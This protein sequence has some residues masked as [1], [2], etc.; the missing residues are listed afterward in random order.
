MILLKTKL[1]RRIASIALGGLVL[2]MVAGIGGFLWLRTSLPERSG[3]VAVGG[4]IQD[5][6]IIYDAHGVPHITA[7]SLGD[8]YRALGYTHAQDRL[9]QMDFMRRLGAGRLSEVVGRQTLRIDRTMR[10]LGLYRLAGKTVEAMPPEA[11]ALL[12][13]YAEGVNAY[14]SHRSGALPPEFLLLGYTPERWRPADSL[15]WGRLMALRLSGNWQTEA[16]RAGMATR[17]SASQIADLWPR[18]NAG[19][20]PTLAQGYDPAA[21][22]SLLAPLLDDLPD[23]LRQ[24]SASN[25]WV[26]GPQHSA[27]GAPLLANDP[28]LGFR[29]PGL[30]Y[31]ARLS[32]PGLDL[33]GATVPGVPFHILG[34]NNR[35]AWAFTT[36]D[37]DTQDLFIERL[38]DGQPGH[39]DTPA[40]PVRFDERTETIRIKGGETV[41][42][43][44]RATRHGPVVSDLNERFRGLLPNDHIVA[45]SA[46]ALSPDDLTPLALLNMNRA[47]SWAEFRDALRN[48]HSPQQNVTYADG[49]GNIGFMAPGRVPVRRNGDGSM[50]AQGWTGEQDW[51]GFIP[52]DELPGTYNPASGRIVN[53]N[54]RIVPETYRWHL[55]HDWAAPYRARRIFDLLDAAP[56]QNADSMGALQNDVV[57]GA[58]KALLPV[59]LSQ[60]ARN[61]SSGSRASTPATRRASQ[62]LGILRGWNGAMRRELSAPLIFTAW[63]GEVNRGL[64]ADELGPYFGGYFGLRPRVVLHLLENSRQWCD[65]VP[66]PGQESCVDVVSTAL[67]RALEDLEQRFGGS[68]D[69]WQWGKA[70]QAFF[71]HPVFGHVPVL[72]NL[73]DIRIESDG[74]A[75]TVNRAQNRISNRRAPFANVHGPGYRAIY[76]L[77][78]PANS[79]FAI[80][81]GQSGNPLSPQYADLLERWRDG[82][83]LGIARTRAAALQDALGRI[84][85]TAAP[86]GKTP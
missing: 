69:D 60:T 65:V 55:S 12:D 17:L 68:P 66:T 75:E 27:T 63:L 25:S 57:S 16:L 18:D 23:A 7:T 73:A 64:Y 46:T 42:L 31:L 28:H 53:A 22:A 51:T 38:S 1:R 21:F 13:A 52:F 85:L 58:A 35:I 30:W 33:A 83:Y 72:R 59:L 15:V 37:S 50:P 54:H 4:L 78:N 44:I 10:T 71:Q 20:P 39:Y 43:K 32:V 2:A 41:D 5:A 3:I 74:G 70:H 36:T 14:L 47:G 67:D 9:F 82:R 81:T 45:L 61:T 62:A 29:A 76:D 6:E 86:K 77:S 8:A 80:A 84:T 79:R 56:V 24:V 19:A 11:R 40:G 49:A 26:V 34:Q 48:F